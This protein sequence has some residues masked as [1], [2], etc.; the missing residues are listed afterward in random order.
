MNERVEM[1]KW[2][3]TLFRKFVVYEYK[4]TKLK[5][6]RAWLDFRIWIYDKFI[7]GG[8]EECK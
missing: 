4:L 2:K 5:M 6:R 8:N 3:V 7:I 1:L